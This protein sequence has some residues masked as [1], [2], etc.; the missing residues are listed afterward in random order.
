MAWFGIVGNQGDL[1]TAMCRHSKHAG[2]VLLR[3]ITLTWLNTSEE[4][5]QWRAVLN[6]VGSTREAYAH[7]G[8]DLEGSRCLDKNNAVGQTATLSCGER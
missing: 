5:K 1:C 4:Q 7:D 6:T 3:S 2:H 8:D